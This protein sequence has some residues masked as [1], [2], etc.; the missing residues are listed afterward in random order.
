MSFLSGILKGLKRVGG[1][2]DKTTD[3]LEPWLTYIPE[4][5]KTIIQVIIQIED[6]AKGDGQGA[7]KKELATKMTTLAFPNINQE[8]LSRNTDKLV[9]ILN[10]LRDSV[11]EEGEMK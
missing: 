6:L 4:P 8:K 11:P 7:L 2:V 3:L 5:A 1:V 9:E 10:D